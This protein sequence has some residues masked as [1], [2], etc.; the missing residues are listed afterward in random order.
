M[1]PPAKEAE[2]PVA[3]PVKKPHPW[4]IFDFL[5][6]LAVGFLL[7]PAA[8]KMAQDDYVFIRWL[9]TLVTAYGAFRGFQKK[10]LV[11][12][13]LFLIP[14]AFFNPFFQLHLGRDL[15]VIVDLA[16]AALFAVSLTQPL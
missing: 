2:T 13:V 1:T 15:W 9:A 6:L 5:K 4:T 14:L 7:I 10:K 8:Q 3:A 11:W 12:G 16:T